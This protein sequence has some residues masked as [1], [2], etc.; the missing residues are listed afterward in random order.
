MG[1]TTLDNS[2][3]NVTFGNNSGITS[4]RN[5]TAPAGVGQAAAG[6]M[7]Y[8]PYIALAAGGVLLLKKLRR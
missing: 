8:A 7:Q 6:L 5:Q 1:G 4:D 3:W 2:G